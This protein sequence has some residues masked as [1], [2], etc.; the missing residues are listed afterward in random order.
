LLAIAAFGLLLGAVSAANPAFDMPSVPA[1]AYDAPLNLIAGLIVS[2]GPSLLSYVLH[3]QSRQ[4]SL[5]RV[6]DSSV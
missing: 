6:G 2:L 3:A 1:P 5:N 4:N